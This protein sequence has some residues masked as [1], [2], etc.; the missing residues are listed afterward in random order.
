MATINRFEDIQAWQEARV[1]AKSVYAASANGGV[2]RDFGLRDQVRRAATSVLSNIAEGFER[3][4]D[5]EFLHFLSLA[6]GSCGEM[7]A[8]LCVALDQGYLDEAAFRILYEHS[9]RISRILG[10]F[11]I[12]LRHSPLRGPKFKSPADLKGR[13]T[14]DP[15]PETV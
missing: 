6:K 7:R 9:D 5:W 15:E 11:M 4:G 10:G 2:A 8:Q 14:L 3:G 12:Y 13:E 1:L